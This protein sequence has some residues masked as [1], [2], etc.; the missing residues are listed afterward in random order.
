MK[1]TELKWNYLL[2]S[3]PL[4]II[5][6]LYLAC[7][8]FFKEKMNIV[9]TDK[10]RNKEENKQ[11]VISKCQLYDHLKR[12]HN[13]ITTKQSEYLLIIARYHMYKLCMELFIF[14]NSLSNAFLEPPKWF[15]RVVVGTNFGSTLCIMENMFPCSEKLESY[16]MPDY[17][18]KRVVCKLEY[19]KIHIIVLNK[20]NV[21][22]FINVL[23]ITLS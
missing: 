8:V 22:N 14:I 2:W 6:H 11:M 9:K 13:S 21:I 18:G 7:Y 3:I 12:Y 5:L 15:Q 16:S 4:S 23:Y 20:H 10:Q 17:I 19:H 1:I